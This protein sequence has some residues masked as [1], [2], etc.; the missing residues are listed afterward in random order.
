MKKL[1]T[2]IVVIALTLGA[3]TAMAQADGFSYQA[4]VRNAAGELVNNSQVGLRLTLTAG[5]GGQTVYQE[6]HTPT[7]N[8]YGVLNVTVGTGKANGGKKLSDVNWAGGDVWM[9]V[10]IDP[11]GGTNYTDMGST[12]LQSVPYAFYALSSTESM[13]VEGREGQTL[14][15]NGTTWVATDEISVKKLDVK[16]ETVTEDA[17]F[18]VKDKDG[19]VVFAVY[20]NGVHV[21]IDPEDD[22][23]KIRR[24]GF[25]ITGRDAT[26]NGENI[27]YLA[28]DGKGTQVFVDDNE[29][30][31]KIKRSGFLIT[32]RDAT[33]EGQPNNY[34]VV[35]DE[36]TKVYV[37]DKDGGDKIKRSGFL[38][39]GRD[40]TKEGQPNNYFAV[41]DEGTKVFIDNTLDGDEAKIKRSGFLITGRDAT[42]DGSA[43]DYMKV[44]TDGT[45]IKFDNDASKIKRSGFLITGRDATKGGTSDV[46]EVTADST[47][48]YVNGGGAKGGFGVEG[49][50]ADGGKGGF[51]VTEKGASGNAGYMNVTA[52]NFFAG[53][54]AGKLT[55]PTTLMFDG[56]ES[57]C[58][59]DN[60][61]V[62]NNAGIANTI[63]TS[64]VFMGN[65]AGYSNTEGGSNVFIG[66]SAGESNIDGQCNVYLGY[67]AGAANK[68]GGQNIYLGYMAGMK[69]TASSNNIF[70]G[71]G[72]G[73]NAYGHYN[74][75][76]GA[77]AGANLYNSKY[78][79]VLGYQAAQNAK[80][81]N[82]TVAIGYQ[83]G[84]GADSTNSENNVFIGYQ[85]GFQNATGSDNVFLGNKAGYSNITG[86]SNVFLG[87][88]AGSDNVSGRWNV[89][90]GNYAGN[91]N[92]DGNS[93]VY[94]GDNS[95]PQAH[96]DNNVFIG[97]CAGFFY[98][99]SS[100][101]PHDPDMP[102]AI[103]ETES[104]RNIAIGY[105]AGNGQGVD[106]ENRES[107]SYSQN[108]MIGEFS[109]MSLYTG[110]QNTLIGA[111]SGPDLSTGS[112]NVII[113][114]WAGEGMKDEC[115]KLCIGQYADH[116]IYGDFNT[117]Y[118]VIKG[119]Y[120]NGKTFYVNG[121]AGGTSEWA[122]N[123]DA[124]L[125]KNVQSLSGA[126]DKVL[127]LRGVTYYWK[128]REEMAA[129]K[130]VAADKMDY[131]Y[132]DKK[133]IGII[134]QELEQEF[135]ELVHTAEDGFKS[136][137][138]S[139]LTPILIEAVKEQQGIIESQQAKIDNQQQQIDE[140][141]RLVE[142]LMKK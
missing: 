68:I 94:I 113:G 140:L 39:T 43:P 128:N 59:T 90:L 111:S 127:K 99:G 10:E 130:G 73:F 34:L 142:E 139:T 64:N 57:L 7:T 75:L 15:H 136:V 58:G 21:Y 95:G 16:A 104:G 112:H 51:A 2:S 27:D 47:R 108:V 109:G 105:N 106:G 117:Q 46:L 5:N 137:E 118:V 63:G 32:G 70:L 88:N 132:D 96:D 92:N 36:G 103:F 80:E 120:R 8:S 42:K 29:D 131:G 123:S 67:K 110:S 98:R 40:A 71:Y 101:R 91:N 54:N 14:V 107:I 89:C 115:N 125:K 102:N 133:H 6:T 93:N 12:K 72:T 4:V 44:A 86:K 81:M 129:A 97:N 31:D 60:T 79:T 24:S 87:V 82:S 138:Y 48:V 76:M 19:N 9:R 55:K 77:H 41:N 69:D 38:I 25:L 85:T 11:N 53:Y 134:A 66:P 124:R 28:V 56:E 1:F 61:F 50:D 114:Y 30:G 126:L 135:P 33:K 35:N 17:L 121:D 122:S 141:R 100:A 26:K 116:L 18:E 22:G 23:N 3:M 49:K 52:E 13:Q 65:K 78:N 119:T 20:P 45:Q 83:A 74:I 84:R 37:D 62:G